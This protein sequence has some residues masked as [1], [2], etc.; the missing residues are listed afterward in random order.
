MPEIAQFSYV[1]GNARPVMMSSGPTQITFINQILQIP[2]Q[3]CANHGPPDQIWSDL[4]LVYLLACFFSLEP[5][6]RALYCLR[7]VGGKLHSIS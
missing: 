4:G 7:E 5:K 2:G 6:N 1:Q 3:E